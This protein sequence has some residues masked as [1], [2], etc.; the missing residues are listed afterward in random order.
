MSQTKTVLI[1]SS[2]VYHPDPEMSSNWLNTQRFVC[3][4]NK[5]A[6]THDKSKSASGAK[7]KMRVGSDS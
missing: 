7:G 2:L 4:N 6:I 3:R 1:R 5:E